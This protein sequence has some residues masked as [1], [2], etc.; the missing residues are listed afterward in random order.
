MFTRYL[1]AIAVT[2]TFLGEEWT[3]LESKIKMLLQSKS[4][5]S[6]DAS[7]Q[8]YLWAFIDVAKFVREARIPRFDELEISKLPLG[9][10]L[11]SLSN[12]SKEF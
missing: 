9:T 5:E 1:A 11:E 2:T 4:F 6:E 8:V 7:L 3:K 12:F 10:L